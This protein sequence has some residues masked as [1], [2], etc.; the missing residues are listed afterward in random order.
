MPCQRLP[1]LTK[2]RRNRSPAVAV[3]GAAVQPAADRDETELA[4]S[5]CVELD[6]GGL[7]EV[8]GIA[9][10]QVHCLDPSPTRQARR[11]PSL[12]ISFAPTFG[13]SARVTG[14]PV[15]RS[16]TV[17]AGCRWQVNEWGN[18]GAGLLI[19]CYLGVVAHARFNLDVLVRW[20]G[21]GKAYGRGRAGGLR[22]S[23]KPRLV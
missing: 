4:G 22:G 19:R 5:V 13:R 8:D 15:C 23:G 1:I 17:G 14:G 21:V 2:D 18:S 6:E 9:V 3:F 20:A 16:C 12:L 7:H 11:L 10:S